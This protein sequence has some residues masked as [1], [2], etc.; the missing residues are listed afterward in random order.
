VTGSNGIDIQPDFIERPNMILFDNLQNDVNTNLALSKF[1]HV[2]YDLELTGKFD[3]KHGDSFYYYNPRIVSNRKPDGT[4]VANGDVT[5]NG[6]LASPNSQMPDGAK[7]TN[8][9]FDNTIKLVAKKIDYS[10]TKPSDAPGGFQR[11]IVGIKRF[12]G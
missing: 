8:G 7:I 10:L 12:V 5:G 11:K 2:E 3:I 6:D 1:R 4:P 9:F